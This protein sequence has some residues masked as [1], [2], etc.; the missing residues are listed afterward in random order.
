MFFNGYD[1]GLDQF[2]LQNIKECV[3]KILSIIKDKAQ[4]L[5]DE[6]KRKC[7]EFGYRSKSAKKVRSLKLNATSETRVPTIGLSNKPIAYF[8]CL[9]SSIL[10]TLNLF[11]ALF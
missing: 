4:E 11:Q 2:K 9:V 5:F 8:H 7:G 10:L 1:R 6:Q 3:L